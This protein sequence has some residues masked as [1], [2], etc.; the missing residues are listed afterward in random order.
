MST[1]LQHGKHYT[2]EELDHRFTEYLSFCNKKTIEQ[3]SAGK[4]LIIKQPEVPTVHGFRCF[5]KESGRSLGRTTWNKYGNGVDGYEPY[6]NTIKEIE[7][8]LFDALVSAMANGRGSVTGHIFNLKVN[9]G[10]QDKQ[11][12]EVSGTWKVDFG[13]ATTDTIHPAPEASGNTSIA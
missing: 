13:T 7:D 8:Y 11:Q 1:T 3:V 10:W 9:H 5:L 2:P 4:I 12:L 6:V